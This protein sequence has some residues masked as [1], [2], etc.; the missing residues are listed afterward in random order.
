MRVTRQ[1]RRHG[2][3]I[4]KA[5]CGR[6]SRRGQLA[7]RLSSHGSPETRRRRVVQSLSGAGLIDPNG[8][9]EIVSYMT[10]EDSLLETGAVGSFR[11]SQ[12]S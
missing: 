12:I 3:W 6:D 8:T 4:H 7:C 11:Q 2:Q 1:D 10:S 9:S 5:F